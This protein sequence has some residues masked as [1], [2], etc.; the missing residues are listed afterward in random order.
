MNLKEVLE[1]WSLHFKMPGDTRFATDVVTLN[2]R[3]T[4][5]D[6]PVGRSESDTL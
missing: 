2:A 5:P 4:G 3:R 1:V 6:S